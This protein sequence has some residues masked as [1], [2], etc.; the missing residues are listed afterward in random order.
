MEIFDNEI[1]LNHYLSNGKYDGY[2][3]KQISDIYKI[4][5]DSKYVRKI[6]ILSEI[7][8]AKH[9]QLCRVKE[10]GFLS[11][12]T[13]AYETKKVVTIELIDSGDN[14]AT[15]FVQ[16]IDDK[17]CT[18]SMLDQY[19]ENDGTVIFEI[20]NVSNL[21]CDGNDEAILKQLYDT[22]MELK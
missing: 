9:D 22:L 17:Y 16:Q 13:Y 15:G 11:L 10:S 3:V 2:I 18:I 20:R 7:N 5:T 1:I 8:K 19:G 4:E 21:S 12:L 6:K 14:D